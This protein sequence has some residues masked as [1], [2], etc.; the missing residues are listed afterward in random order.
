MPGCISK[1]KRMASSR[2][3]L[4]PAKTEFI[5]CSLSKMFHRVDQVTPF[6]IDGI[7]VPLV[8]SIKIL[9]V[10]IDCD[11]SCQSYC[12]CM[13]LSA[14]YIK[15]ARQSLPLESAKSLVQAIVMSR[16]NVLIYKE[17]NQIF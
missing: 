4:N 14:S 11:G 9:G 2:L 12:E 7:T 17:V 13:L 10:H 6:F 5:W 16:L 3:G 1:V 8:K 15:A